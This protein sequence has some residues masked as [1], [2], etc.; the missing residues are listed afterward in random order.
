M[1]AAVLVTANIALFFNSFVLGLVVELTR[2]TVWLLVRSSITR[3]NMYPRIMY[4]KP[5]N[6]GTAQLEQNRGDPADA[7]GFGNDKGAML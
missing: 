5:S 1:M 7:T 6:G 4:A 3:G 2:E